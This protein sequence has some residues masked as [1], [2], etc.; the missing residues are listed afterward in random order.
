[1]SVYV[2][3]RNGQAL[4][5]AMGQLHTAIAEFHNGSGRRTDVILVR[6]FNRHDTL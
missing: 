2:E 3:G 5:A 4:E 6:D 1:M